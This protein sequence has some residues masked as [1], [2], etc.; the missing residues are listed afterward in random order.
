MSIVKNWQKN[1]RSVREWNNQYIFTDNMTA[2]IY[3]DRLQEKQKLS[4]I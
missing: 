1:D 4:I 3:H 2:C